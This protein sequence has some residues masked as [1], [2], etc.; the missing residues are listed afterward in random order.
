[1]SLSNLL[2]GLIFDLRCTEMRAFIRAIGFIS[3]WSGK[4][5]SFLWLPVVLVIVYEVIL[6]Y[7]FAAPTIWAHEVMI[8]LCA[9]IYIMGGAYT[10]YLRKHISMDIFYSRYSLRGRAILDL[11]TFPFFCLF[12]GALLW[13]G[14]DRA[15]DAVMIMET[16]G[17]H[18]NPPIWPVLLLIPLGALLLLLQGLSK[19]IDDLTTVIGRK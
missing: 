9:M 3:E 16:T 12:V 13:A 5:F 7:V 19:F 10:Q 4:I 6:R 18:W 1:M 17:T 2:P 11:I 14:A 15:W 8:Y